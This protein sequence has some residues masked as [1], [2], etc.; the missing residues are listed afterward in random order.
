MELLALTVGLLAIGGFF[1]VGWWFLA[2]SLYR[3]I[4]DRDFAVQVG[5]GPGLPA[6]SC[7]AGSLAVLP[8]MPSRLM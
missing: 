6:S 8:S 4:D 1:W 2:R 3:N 7:P 5:F